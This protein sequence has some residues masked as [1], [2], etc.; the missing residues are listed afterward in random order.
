MRHA[1]FGRFEHLY[2]VFAPAFRLAVRFRR[3]T[4]GWLSLA[5]GA[6]EQGVSTSETTAAL[7]S[8]DGL[9]ADDVYRRGDLSDQ[10]LLES[11]LRTL[12]ERPGFIRDGGSR[13]DVPFCILAGMVFAVFDWATRV[14][15]NDW[16]Q[17]LRRGRV[18]RVFRGLALVGATFGRV[19]ARGVRAALEKVWSKIP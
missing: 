16:L 14:A 19:C 5:A 17:S 15:R 10:Y 2:R 1:L 7:P 13:D 18:C 11:V 6:P 3:Q 4:L 12:Y 9:S 8:K